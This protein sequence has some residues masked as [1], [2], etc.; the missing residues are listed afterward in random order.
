MA[1]NARYSGASPS[2]AAPAA[3]SG[4]WSASGAT[5]P[6]PAA[7][8]PGVAGSAS[9]DESSCLPGAARLPSAARSAE[10]QILAAIAILTQRAD[11]ESVRQQD[12]AETI[13]SR[14]SNLE[15]EPSRA[16]APPS[17]YGSDSSYDSDASSG[18]TPRE[19]EYLNVNA[20]NRHWK[21]AERS[22]D[23]D[24]HPRR[25]SL[26]G[27]RPFDILAAGKHKGG[28]TLGVVMSYIEPLC[29]YLQTALDGVREAAELAHE[30][31][32]GG[33]DLARLLDATDNT[34]SSVY[35]LGNTLR[36][37]VTERAEVTAPGCTQG[38]KLRQQWVE[39]QINEDDLG[40][41]DVAPRVR[42][43]KAAYDYEAGKQ[44]LR[45]AANGGGASGSHGNSGS[46][47]KSFGRYT[48]KQEQSKSSRRRERERER[49][50]DDSSKRDAKSDTKVEPSKPAA[51]TKPKYS[52]QASDADSAGDKGKSRKGDAP[53]RKA[54]RERGRSKPPDRA[55]G[56]GGSS[57]RSAGR[58]GGGS[59]RG[60]RRARSDGSDSGVGASD[61]GDSSN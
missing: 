16:S 3:A 60:G 49:K 38:D 23:V 46:L 7:G 44:D 10:E 13:F 28:G 12:F 5:T 42:K 9:A 1:S 50:R 15:A 30:L 37:L 55:G 54:D 14:L 27:Y 20:R 40:R 6:R 22:Q 33:A 2:P 8:E 45:K 19:K 53:A 31:P 32:R 61:S 25:H 57:R 34:L 51:T 52:K 29:L 11:A 56:G 17:D 48:S 26:Y 43:L 21:A 59:R 58:D 24:Q 39:S 47:G 18:S 35:G 41:A 36:T 4:A